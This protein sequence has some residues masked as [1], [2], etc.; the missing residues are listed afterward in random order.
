M[1]GTRG[2]DPAAPGRAALPQQPG[3][4]LTI[5]KRRAD[6][7]SAARVAHLVDVGPRRHEE[8]VR[9]RIGEGP[10]V[11]AVVAGVGVEHLD[12]VQVAGILAG[13]VVAVGVRLDEDAVRRAAHG[14]VQLLQ[15]EEGQARQLRELLRRDAVDEVVLR[16]IV[17]AHFQ[18]GEH[19]QAR[20]AA[21]FRCAAVPGEVALQ[22]DAVVLA[23]GMHGEELRRVVIGDKQGVVP[24]GAH[25]LDELL[26]RK[27]AAGAH[28]RGVRMG[29]HP[30]KRFHVVPPSVE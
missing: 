3:E 30:P 4:L 13:E 17:Q 20:L 11:V 5:R 23:R 7:G 9:L 12:A 27:A 24:R 26:R 2:S 1:R 14:R 6:H 22:I 29:L 10:V 19:A 28:G 8:A 18:P 25:L 15:G 16:P 21:G